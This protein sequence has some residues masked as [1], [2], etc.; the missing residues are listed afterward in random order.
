M[1]RRPFFQKNATWFFVV[2]LAK[3][4]I[5]QGSLA[6][7]TTRTPMLTPCRLFP[8][9]F[10]ALNRPKLCEPWLRPR[11]FCGSNALLEK[12]TW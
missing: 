2:D 1:R 9:N 8:L 4:P 3:D 6:R 7:F 12:I 5:W 11:H 10:T